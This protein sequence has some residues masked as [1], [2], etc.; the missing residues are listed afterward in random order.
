MIVYTQKKIST[1]TNSADPNEMSRYA[2]FHSSLYCWLKYQFRSIQNPERQY[3]L[4][5]FYTDIIQCCYFLFRT[6]LYQGC[7]ISSVLPWL[8]YVYSD[9]SLYQRQRTLISMIN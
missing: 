3:M 6:C 4:L 9:L 7:C 5:P 8:G 1:L 2:T